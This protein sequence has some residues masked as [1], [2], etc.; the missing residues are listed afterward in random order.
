MTFEYKPRTYAQWLKRASKKAWN[1]IGKEPKAKRGPR[2]ICV[3]GHFLKDHCLDTCT[4]ETDGA[5]IHPDVA[6]ETPPGWHTCVSTHCTVGLGASNQ[7]CSCLCFRE[8]ESDPWK[9]KPRQN[10]ADDGTPCDD[11]WRKCARCSHLRRHHCTKRQTKKAPSSF[12]DWKGFE[13]DGVP[14]Q[15]KHT[16]P[17]GAPYQCT[18]SACAEEGCDCEKYVNPL[19]KPR[20]KPAKPRAPRKRKETTAF[21]TGQFSLAQPKPQPIHRR[22]AYELQTTPDRNYRTQ[23]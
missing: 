11:E 14:Y 20:K 12:E 5:F 16:L 9:A 3:C 23:T 13:V 22:T 2:S 1:A 18:S 21:V 4:H 19:L 17:N 15:C 6:A 10:T 8:K 7:R